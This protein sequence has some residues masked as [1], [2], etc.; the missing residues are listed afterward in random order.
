MKPAFDMEDEE[1][2]DAVRA[3]AR[4]ILSTESSFWYV[5]VAR[6][7]ELMEEHD[8]KPIDHGDHRYWFFA[9]DPKREI[10]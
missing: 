8:G 3:N 1:L 9:D 5:Y 6:M 7:K 2:L 4:A 10:P